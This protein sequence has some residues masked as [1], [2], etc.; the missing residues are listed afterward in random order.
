MELL[1][2]RDY[3]N[4]NINTKYGDD[5]ITGAINNAVLLEMVDS[6]IEIVGTGFGGDISPNDNPGAQVKP[7]HF[8]ASEAGVYT[9]CGGVTVTTL[10]AYIVWNGTEWKAKNIGLPVAAANPNQCQGLAFA[11]D[12]APVGKVVNDWYVFVGGGSLAWPGATKT[13]PGIVYLKSIN[14]IGGITVYDWAI[15]AFGG[16]TGTGLTPEQAADVAKIDAIEEVANSAAAAAVAAAEL[17][18]DVGDGLEAHTNETAEKKH[19]TNQITNLPALTKLALAANTNVEAILAAID[20]FLAGT[21]NASAINNADWLES[22][23][24]LAVLQKTS[25]I[26][27]MSGA[28]LL[29]DI[30]GPPDVVAS[31]N[32]QT[33]WAGESKTLTGDNSTGQL[34]QKGQHVW[35]GNGHYAECIEANMAVSGSAQYVRNL[36]IHV[37]DPYNNTQDAALANQLDPSYN[38][39]AMTVTGV[40]TD[41]GWNLTS[42]VKVINGLP[43]R[44][45]MWFIGGINGDGYTYHC[46][47]IV[48]TTSYWKRTGVPESFQ[49]PISAMTHPTLVAHLLAY[50]FTSST[51]APIAGDEACYPEQ[52]YWHP[53]TRAKYEMQLDG[54]WE[55]L[56]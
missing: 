23:Q 18:N 2:L 56:K 27:N 48:G 11:G 6:L 15:E 36:S 17:A 55:K 33:G 47:L 46:F 45:S 21:I 41:S 38:Y 28:A 35:L 13:T 32:N 1:A 12:A 3:I 43:A 39:P 44:L 10:P 5:R 30:F 22:E 8:L 7:I 16:G 52:T 20:T 9:Y 25:G 29:L 34:G 54:K 14:V 31:L 4:Q 53:A 51:Y 19:A 24:R 50:D 37:L 49:R 40:S 42:M 26:I